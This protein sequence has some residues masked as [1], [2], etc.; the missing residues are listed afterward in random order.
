MII[1]TKKKLL[2]IVRLQTVGLSF[3]F[4]SVGE[5]TP[6]YE[7]QLSSVEDDPA[8]RS[9]SDV[10]NRSASRRRSP[11]SSPKLATLGRPPGQDA[12]IS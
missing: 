8:I 11:T 4:F 9:A 10:G 6:G 12:G 1:P 5:R 2:V 3:I 7:N